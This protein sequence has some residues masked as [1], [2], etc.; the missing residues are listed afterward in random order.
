[1]TRERD[2]GSVPIAEI[3]ALASEVHHL[4]KASAETNIENRARFDRI[5][6]VLDELVK[7]VHS[8]RTLTRVVAF[9]IPLILVIG[10]ALVPFLVRSSIDDVLIQRGILRVEPRP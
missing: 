1:M 3:E 10:A 9:A 5:D 4:E 6:R 2:E 8:G 7:D